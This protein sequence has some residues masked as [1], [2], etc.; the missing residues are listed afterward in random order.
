MLSSTD[1]SECPEAIYSNGL[2]HRR[3]KSIS[4][5]ALV[6]TFQKDCTVFTKELSDRDECS[7]DVESTL[8][9]CF[10]RYITGNVTGG[11]SCQ[12]EAHIW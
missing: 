9:S 4:A 1:L 12:D 2:L 8:I 3:N 10:S 6:F 7:K 5:P 11:N